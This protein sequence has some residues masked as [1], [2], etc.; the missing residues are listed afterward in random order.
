MQKNVWHY[1]SIGVPPM[2]S[3]GSAESNQEVCTRTL[4]EPALKFDTRS[5]YKFL[6]QVS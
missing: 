1:F 5:M 4:H 2:A 3:K 6:G